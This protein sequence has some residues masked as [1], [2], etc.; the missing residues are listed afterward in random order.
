VNK[1]V[2][3]GYCGSGKVE[4]VYGVGKHVLYGLGLGLWFGMCCVYFLML[5]VL[6]PS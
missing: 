1:V 3:G 5:Y 6:F 4:I 2:L